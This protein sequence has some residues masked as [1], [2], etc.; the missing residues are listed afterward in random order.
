MLLLQLLCAAENDSHGSSP[1]CKDKVGPNSLCLCLKCLHH[2]LCTTKGATTLTWRCCSCWSSFSCSV[3]TSRRV[4]GVL[5]TYCTHS[6]PSSVHSL[7]GKGQGV[8]APQ[9]CRWG[10]C[11]VHLQQ[12][13]EDVYGVL[14]RVQRGQ[15]LHRGGT[16]L[17]ALTCALV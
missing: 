13:I 12:A 3:M 10:S 15:A 1:G 9:T 5:D 6:C 7:Q 14:E 2:H 11:T 8:H 4:A 17:Q 16:R